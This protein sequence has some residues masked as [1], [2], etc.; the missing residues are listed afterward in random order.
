MDR[1]IQ[2]LKDGGISGNILVVYSNHFAC[3]NRCT[4]VILLPVGP[5]ESLLIIIK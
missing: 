4:L 3:V 2:R 5:K 1:Q